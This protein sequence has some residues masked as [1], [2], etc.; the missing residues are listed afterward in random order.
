MALV[1]FENLMIYHMTTAG[2]MVKLFL[3]CSGYSLIP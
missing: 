1:T 2:K 3:S